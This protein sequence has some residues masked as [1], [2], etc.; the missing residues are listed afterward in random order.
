MSALSLTDAE[1]CTT[2]HDS[3]TDHYR[4]AIDVLADDFA[5]GRDYGKS[6]PNLYGL[7]K[8]KHFVICFDFKRKQK[9]YET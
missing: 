5:K 3:H 8:L 2:S 4:L 1:G 9:I 7:F 6:R